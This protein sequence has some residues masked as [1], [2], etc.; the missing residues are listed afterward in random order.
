VTDK[1]TVMDL[2]SIANKCVGLDLASGADDCS[3]LNLHKGTDLGLITGT[4]RDS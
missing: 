4:H 1:D 2:H 3:P